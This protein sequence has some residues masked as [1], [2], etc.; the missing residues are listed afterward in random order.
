M[1]LSLLILLAEFNCCYGSKI[2][3]IFVGHR[4]GWAL[5]VTG[6]WAQ[7]SGHQHA[8]DTTWLQEVQGTGEY[9][10]SGKQAQAPVG[11]GIPT[12]H[13]QA[14]EGTIGPKWAAATTGHYQTMEKN[15][16]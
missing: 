12:W 9:W 3:T 10:G 15:N 4:H 6:R 5:V 1:V 7:G 13:H 8:M 11:H 14:S 2:S 16:G